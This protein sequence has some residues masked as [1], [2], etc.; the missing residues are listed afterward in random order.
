MRREF[1]RYFIA[2]SLAF[3][4]DFA[5]LFACTEYLGMHYLLSNVFGYATGLCIA[6]LLN[7]KWVFS[8]RK[9]SRVTVEFTIFNVIVIAGLILSEVFMYLLVG[10]LG[11]YYL[12]AKVVA[13]MLVFGFNYVA[14]KYVLFHPGINAGRVD[15]EAG[16]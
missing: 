16:G 7:V 9:Y 6:Y 1:V 11:L 2:G 4:G 8:F 14:K 12:H 3:A 10:L 5:V 13:S 15:R